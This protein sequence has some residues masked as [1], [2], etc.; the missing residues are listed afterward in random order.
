MGNISSN[1]SAAGVRAR[2]PVV[3]RRVATAPRAQHC[4]PARIPDERWTRAAYERQFAFLR[5][6]G[7]KAGLVTVVGRRVDACLCA[8]E[9]VNRDFARRAFGWLMDLWSASLPTVEPRAFTILASLHDF[10]RVHEDAAPVYSIEQGANR[11]SLPTFNSFRSGWPDE[12]AWSRDALLTGV[13]L[14]W[15]ER[16][17][18]LVW[19]G[20]AAS[21]GNSSRSLLLQ[22][23]R[24]HPARID[25]R[26]TE[27]AGRA[28][29]RLTM[30]QQERF[31][32][33][34]SLPGMLDAYPW[35]V[36]E[37]FLRGFLVFLVS[38]NGRFAAQPAFMCELKPHVHY[39]PVER[40]LRSLLELLEW[41]RTHDDDAR[42]IASAGQLAMR[43]VYNRSELARS[44]AS[45]LWAAP[46][47]ECMA[48]PEHAPNNQRSPCEHVTRE[49][50][51]PPGAAASASVVTAA[52]S[53]SA[54]QPRD[55]PRS[56]SR[57]ASHPPARLPPSAV[58][59][60]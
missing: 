14:A 36:P 59:G 48:C 34:I 45:R 41:A 53:R 1:A 7:Q 42:R 49:L 30:E 37:L 26:D 8:E 56:R 51:P 10:V 31:R 22:L 2:G 16:K 32:F 40:S 11:I 47:H 3:S 29:H 33:T 43:R 17:P 13:R 5:Q 20:S 50:P 57:L 46:L 58:R 23:A 54:H 12:A 44:L 9:G 39:L 55:C 4:R 6:S 60:R 28:A 27:G 35:R 18:V 52:A 24:R 21:Y 25:A 19:R 15:R 38:G